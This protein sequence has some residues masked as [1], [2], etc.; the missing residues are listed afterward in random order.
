MCLVPA[1]VSLHA[2]IVKLGWN[3]TT[4]KAAF[5]CHWVLSFSV[6][7]WF[8]ITLHFSFALALKSIHVPVCVNSTDLLIYSLVFLGCHWVDF[9]LLNINRDTLGCT[10]VS[11]GVPCSPMWF[12]DTKAKPVSYYSWF[13]VGKLIS[14]Y[15]QCKWKLLQGNFKKSLFLLLRGVSVLATSSVR[16]LSANDSFITLIIYIFSFCLRRIFVRSIGSYWSPV[17]TAN[18]PCLTKTDICYRISNV[19]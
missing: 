5:I 7:S 14:D 15:S 6:L 19:L 17:R 18:F 8:I 11:V 2:L 10:W 9:K 3:M 1:E 4:R 13:S 12:I 16:S